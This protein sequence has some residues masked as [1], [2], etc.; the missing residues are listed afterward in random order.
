M[1]SLLNALQLIAPLLLVILVGVGLRKLGL[2]NDQWVMVLNNLAFYVAF[3]ALT[4]ISLVDIDTT[5]L[6]GNL[7]LDNAAALINDM[8]IIKINKKISTH[9]RAASAIILVATMFGNVAYLGYPLSEIAFGPSGLRLATIIGSIHVFVYFTI[10]VAVAEYQTVR[11]LR[12]GQIGW[13]ILRIPLVWAVVLGAV[14]AY[15]GVSPP[16][17]AA[18]S[19]EILANAATAVALLALGIFVAGLSLR[20][21]MWV[22]ALVTALK[23]VVLP[24]IAWALAA[25]MQLEGQQRTVSILQAAMPVGISTFAVADKLGMDREVSA[26]AILATTVLSVLSL[27]VLLALLS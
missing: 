18:T 5:Q 3:P 10:V 23:L 12:L 2:A 22:V 20:G 9:V 16:T 24:A 15:L 7:I 27:P 1:T 26:S 6:H 4:F 8:E 17:F 11:Q 13:R 19:F 21:R 25:P 14:V